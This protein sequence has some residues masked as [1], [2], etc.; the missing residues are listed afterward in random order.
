MRVIPEFY[1]QKNIISFLFLLFGSS[2]IAYSVCSLGNF[3]DFG[4]GLMPTIAGSAMI[5]F[6]I[7]DILC[8]AN[9]QTEKYDKTDIQCVGI[10]SASVLFYV[11]ISDA[12]GFILTGFI[13]ITSLMTQYAQCG[14]VKSAMI[15]F[16][17]VFS[18]YLLFA[19]VLSV[20][21]PRLFN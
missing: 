2:L 11:L 17:V 3:A 5:I 9:S 7:A 18:T 12:L 10:I 15:A 21:L 8:S 20:P 19:K 4:A 16:V 1:D 13:I 6:S 14:R